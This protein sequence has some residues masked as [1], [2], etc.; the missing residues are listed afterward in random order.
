MDLANATGAPVALSV[1][2]AG[3]GS[4]STSCRVRAARE[5]RSPTR[6]VDVIARSLLGGR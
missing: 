3:Q 4:S 5:A 1:E 6:P 2:M